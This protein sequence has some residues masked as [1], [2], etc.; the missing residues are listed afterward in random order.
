MR[1]RGNRLDHSRAL[2]LARLMQAQEFLIFTNMPARTQCDGCKCS[3]Y[4]LMSK[5][6]WI[7]WLIDRPVRTE[8]CPNNQATQVSP[9]NSAWCRLRVRASLHL[10]HPEQPV[11]WLWYVVS[12]FYVGR[13]HMGEV[14]FV[15]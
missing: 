8:G 2:R 4:K 3:L 14:L 12:D 10:L 9:R 13:V 6:S 15:R 7:S 11:V 5:L 1:T